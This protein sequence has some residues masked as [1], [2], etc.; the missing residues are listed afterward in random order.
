ML[1]NFLR[2]SCGEHNE[3]GKLNIHPIRN[4]FQMMI[5]SSMAKKKNIKTWSQETAILGLILIAV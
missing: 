2:R 5:H 4:C 3:N 1:E